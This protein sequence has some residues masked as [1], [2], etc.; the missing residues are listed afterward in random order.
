MDP[1]PVGM[2]GI[3]PSLNT[4]F[5]ADGAVDTAS[6]GRLVEATVAAG[7]GGMLALAVAGEGA[8]LDRDEKRRALA[9]IV[10][11]NAGRLPLIAS[12]S[13]GAQDERVALSRLARELGADGVCCQVPA[14]LAG[15]AL[16]RALAEVAGAGPGLLMLQDLD[17]TGDGLA[18][19]EIVRLFE[20]VPGFRCLKVETVPAGP[21]YSRV[22]AA[23]GGR[24]HVSGGW[25]VTQMLDG[26]ARGV[27]AFVPTGLEPVYCAIHRAWQA[28]RQPE[29]QALFEAALPVLAFANQHVDVSIRFLKRLRRAEG[30]FATDR[31]R[32]PVAELDP[33]QQRQADALVVRALALQ[34]E[35]ARRGD[36]GEDPRRHRGALL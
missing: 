16:E 26:L 5:D 20:R 3:V 36:A 35:A 14:G 8:S 19:E 23:T 12:V 25:A 10:A 4:P 2:R 30:L 9:A 21:K 28:S 13:A 31:C 17:W 27:H 32:P 34:T 18:L 1:C 11:A 15:E 6:L 29:A 22:L 33:V 24:L 7:C